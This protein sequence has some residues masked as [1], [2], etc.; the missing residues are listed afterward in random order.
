MKVRL[1]DHLQQIRTFVRVAECGS[2]S[3]VA[4]QFGTTQS[5]VSKH[6]AALES[7]LGASLMSR[8]TRA[9]SLTEAGRQY[10][11]D[12]RRLVD[13]LEEIE[14]RLRSGQAK[15]SGTLR[16][17]SSVGF[18][19]RVLM[20]LVK[21]FLRQHPNVVIEMHLSDAFIDIV[22]LGMD[23]SIRLGE[24]RDSSL[25]ARRIGEVCRAIV[26]SPD[27]IAALPPEIGV[28]QTPDDLARHNCILYTEPVSQ[29]EW[30]FIGPDG[31]V[32]RVSVSGALRTNSSE[33]IREAALSGMGICY[34]PT[35]LVADA[36]KSARLR[37]LLPNWRSRLVPVHAIRPP[38]REA[39]LKATAFIAH[40]TSAGWEGALGHATD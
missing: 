7:R 13:E 34:A 2:F 4:R 32:V 19:S 24:L 16:V 26:A 37:I 40:L 1:I 22:E 25:V 39:S 12:A 31:A 30:E 18:G 35:W 6:I 23:V 8:T 14:A 20:P 9:L 33:V 15:L 10:F 36:I 21:T 28:P 38:Q 11:N 3:A 17:A 29:G 5:A 27:Y